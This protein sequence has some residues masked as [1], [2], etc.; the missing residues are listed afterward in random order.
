MEAMLLLSLL[1][2]AYFHGHLIFQISEEFITILYLR[3]KFYLHHAKHLKC[4]Y[5]IFLK[6]ANNVAN[7]YDFN[8]FRMFSKHSTEDILFISGKS[9][10][11]MVI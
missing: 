5:K 11:I 8:N 10:S 2:K 1:I 4:R 6:K 9:L 3:V 7:T